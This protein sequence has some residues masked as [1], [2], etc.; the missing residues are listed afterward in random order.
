MDT[1]LGTQ[2]MSDSQCKD[3]RSQLGGRDRKNGAHNDLEG[4]AI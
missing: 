3:L 1:D 4:T 2:R